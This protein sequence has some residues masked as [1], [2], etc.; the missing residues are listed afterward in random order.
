M[1]QGVTPGTYCETP[2]SHRCN[3]IL[4]PERF[5]RGRPRG[6]GRG[7]P[8]EVDALAPLVCLCRGE[9]YEDHP[10]LSGSISDRHTDAHV[11]TQTPSRAERA[12]RLGLGPWFELGVL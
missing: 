2:L 5:V 8:P 11:Q 10:E 1:N 4:H 9:V 12:P 6:L 7:V 3:G